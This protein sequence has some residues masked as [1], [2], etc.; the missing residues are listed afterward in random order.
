M[1]TALLCHGY[2]GAQKKVL[3][4][5]MIE[6]AQIC[7]CST[8]PLGPKSQHPPDQAAGPRAGPALL[9]IRRWLCRLTRQ[10]GLALS[11]IAD[12]VGIYYDARQPSQLEQ[13][14]SALLALAVRL[15]ADLVRF[16]I[17]KYNGYASSQAHLAYPVANGAGWVPPATM[18]QVL[19]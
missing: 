15:M 7:V 5:S 16:G 2:G 3:L 4:I 14:D 10:G 12:P 6:T 19:S 18:A 11:F 9:E 13:L 17:T 8:T 1:K